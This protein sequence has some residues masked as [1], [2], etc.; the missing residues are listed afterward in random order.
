MHNNILITLQKYNCNFISKGGW[1]VAKKFEDITGNVAIEVGDS[2][3][4]SAVDNGTFK[5]GAARDQ[6]I[7]IIIVYDCSYYCT[8]YYMYYFINYTV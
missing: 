6:G 4:V 5:L 8:T 7:N 2:R 1:W 3:Y